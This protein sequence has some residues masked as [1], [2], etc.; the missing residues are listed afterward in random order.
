MTTIDDF[1][2][3][4]ADDAEWISPLGCSVE[5]HIQEQLADPEFRREFVRYA[6]AEAVARA[7]IRFRA[8]RSLTQRE[9][10]SVLGLPE[11]TIARLERGD[12]IPSADTL[13]RVAEATGTILR[14]SFEP[15]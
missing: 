4:A 3:A 14:V 7:L 6:T 5:E 1:Q 15:R 10:A 2:E 11:R 12:R 9:A 8:E 13:V